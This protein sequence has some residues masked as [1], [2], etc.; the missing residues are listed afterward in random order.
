MTTGQPRKALLADLQWKALVSSIRS[1][2]K[3]KL[4]NSLAIADVSG[5]MG[6]V[7]FPRQGNAVYPILPCIALSLLLGE[8]AEDPWN[9]CFI[10]FSTNPTIQRIDTSLPLSTRAKTLS[11]ASWEMTTNFYKVF[12]LLLTTA[13]RENVPADRMVKTL[14]VFSDMQFNQAVSG[15]MAGTEHQMARELFR[16]AG[17]DLPNIVFWNLNQQDNIDNTSKPARAMENGVQLMSGFSGALM[18][19]FLRGSQE[20]KEDEKDRKEWQDLDDRMDGMEKAEK[21]KGKNPLETVMAV[22]GQ[23]CFENLVVVD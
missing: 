12:E 18:K 4:D 9:G 3:P 13:K 21:S 1:S 2:S 17:Y 19:F 8:L 7:S 14:Y 15:G 6:S 16:K 5:S 11:T 10:T 22:I 20:E 23:K